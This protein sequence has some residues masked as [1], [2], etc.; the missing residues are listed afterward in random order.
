[1]NKL[2]QILFAASIFLYQGAFIQAQDNISSANAVSNQLHVSLLEQLKKA[3]LMNQYIGFMLPSTALKNKDEIQNYLSSLQNNIFTFQD[4]IYEKIVR[5]ENSLS[6]ED[7]TKLL[8]FNSCIIESLNIATKSKFTNLKQLESYNISSKTIEQQIEE[9]SKKL[10]SI[11]N[12][13]EYMGL[14]DFNIWYRELIEKDKLH[15]I[16][17]GKVTAK[18]AFG[19]ASSIFIVSVALNKMTSEY[20]LSGAQ[21]DLVDKINNLRDRIFNHDFLSKWPSIAESILK[22][23]GVSVS[24]LAQ[25][26]MVGLFSISSA[27]LYKE[28][29]FIY[30]HISDKIFNAKIKL[31]GGNFS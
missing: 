27:Y 8:E 20:A 11:E 12:K 19:I 6:E 9:N 3:D 16:Y 30:K 13:I 4:S 1:M 21:K 25:P 22:G 2:K 10:E 23:V 18:L 17:A 24:G 7:I 29:E 5:G 31:R 26:K 28:R 14:S 15:A